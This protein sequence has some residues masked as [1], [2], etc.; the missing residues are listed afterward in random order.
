MCGILEFFFQFDFEFLRTF[1]SFLEF[2]RIFKNFVNSLFFKIFQLHFMIFLLNCH[3]SVD[4]HDFSIEF[5]K[6]LQN[7]ASSVWNS[8]NLKQFPI[9]FRCEPCNRTFKTKRAL[10]VHT[11]AH[12]RQTEFPC[13]MCSKV[14]PTFYR[15][16]KHMKTHL[17]LRKCWLCSKKCKSIADLQEHMKNDHNSGN[18]NI[19]L[20]YGIFSESIDFLVTFQVEWM[21]NWI[22]SGSI[23]IKPKSINIK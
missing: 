7:C 14:W 2:S 17:G 8:R 18:L 1:E 5:M 15:L 19:P 9:L 16:K 23:I 22:S 20:I 3:Y 6:K 21:S 11:V 4:F 12:R 10:E 13:K